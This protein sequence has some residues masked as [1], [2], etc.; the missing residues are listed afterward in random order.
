MT[1]KKPFAPPTPREVG[2]V[3]LETKAEAV[4]R[5]V[6]A[7]GE[8]GHEDHE[9]F[10]ILTKRVE[11]LTAELWRYHHQVVDT[12]ARAAEHEFEDRLTRDLYEA[13]V[14]VYALRAMTDGRDRTERVVSGSAWEHCTYMAHDGANRV[15]KW[16]EATSETASPQERKLEVAHA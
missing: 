16:L 8:T 14:L 4:K 1:R 9:F 3:R 11:D 2:R 5:A 15:L 7:L 10:A 12:P 6:A 13:P